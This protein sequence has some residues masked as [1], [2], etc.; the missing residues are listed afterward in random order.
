MTFRDA[1]FL[2]DLAPGSAMTISV[3]A[4]GGAACLIALVRSSAGEV[5]ALDDECSHGRASLG[6]GDVE[7][8][9]GPGGEAAVECW[10]HG[11]QFDARTGRP[12]NLPATQPVATYPVR[13]EARDEGE[14]V[15]VDADAPTLAL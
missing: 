10:K 2:D 13:I 12:L 5:F 9:G 3:E 4:D 11:S 7:D 15:Q 6:D 1:A 14:I 8:S